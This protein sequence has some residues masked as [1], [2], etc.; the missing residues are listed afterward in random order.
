MKLKAMFLV[1][2][3]IVLVSC[4]KNK[5]TGLEPV[6]GPAV[7]K[8]FGTVSALVQQLSFHSNGFSI[9]GDWRFPYSG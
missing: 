9:V 7:T 6:Y 5:D 4:E 8:Q 3:T 1:L 2:L